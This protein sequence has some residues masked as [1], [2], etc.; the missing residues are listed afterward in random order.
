MKI[1][2]IRV[3]SLVVCGC[4]LLGLTAGQVSAEMS[5]ITGVVPTDEYTFFDFEDFKEMC[6]DAAVFGETM[7]CVYTGYVDF[8]LEESLTIPSTLTLKTD[9]AGIRIPS[10][11]TVTLEGKMEGSGIQVE[12]TLQ[13]F[14]RLTLESGTRTGMTVAPTGSYV[15]AEGTQSGAIFVAADGEELPDNCISGMEMSSFTAQK[16][17][18]GEDTFW[19][20]TITQDSG[21]NEEPDPFPGGTPNPNPNPGED[22]DPGVDPDLGEDP[23]PT[24]PEVIEVTPMYRLYNPNSGEHFYTG[25]IEERD[26]LIGLGWIYEG[27]AWNAPTETGDP[28]YRLYNP[29]SGD[30]HY[31]MSATERDWLASL[32][33]QY[34]GVCWN[35]AS[36]DNLPQYR[37]YN[38]NADC[39]SHHYTG[40]AEERD[41]LVS[42]GWHYEGIGWF[43]MLN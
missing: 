24:D 12:G 9:G 30:H 39:G 2:W 4:M 37:L 35:S 32:G 31:T 13:N 29:N 43:G 11:V 38:P 17:Q 33:W 18:D 3:L 1:A 25:S 8:V 10:G 21:S 42:L 14:G 27:V 34:E 15:D 7:T 5:G 23:K 28:V 26:M 40:S 41:F 16:V 22:P 19:K 20:L 6:Q 36:S